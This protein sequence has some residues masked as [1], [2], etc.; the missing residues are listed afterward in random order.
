[1]KN[2]E[3]PSARSL[4]E[5]PLKERDTSF[6]QLGSSALSN[7]SDKKVISPTRELTSLDAKILGERYD[8]TAP[9]AEM[10]MLS[11]V[12]TAETAAYNQ[13][14]QEDYWRDKGLI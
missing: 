9:D 13:K 8:P 4:Y 3:D 12:V 2:F 5:S 10:V 7:I 11:D 1:M 6:D 14:K